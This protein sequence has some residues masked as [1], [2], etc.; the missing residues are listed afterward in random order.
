MFKS[1]FESN[2]ISANMALRVFI[3]FFVVSASYAC[4]VFCM[5]PR[6]SSSGF[7]LGTHY[8]MVHLVNVY[9]NSHLTV[10]DNDQL[11]DSNRRKI[12]IEKLGTTSRH[13][14]RLVPHPGLFSKMYVII[15]HHTNEPLCAT[16]DEFDSDSHRRN[17]ASW[18]PG[19]Y[20]M[21]CF[22]DIKRTTGGYYT[23]KNLKY[24]EYTYA[25]KN[26]RYDGG[27]RKVWSWKPKDQDEDKETQFHWDII[28]LK[29]LCN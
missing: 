7:K 26:D 13:K 22:W 3:L 24:G 16:P 9:H 12:A 15:H 1:Q 29:K 19:P 17:V 20:D 11:W 28:N 25:A 21:S 8:Q 2:L 18:I 6:S 5:L 4:R 23:L 10:M 14:W 27:L